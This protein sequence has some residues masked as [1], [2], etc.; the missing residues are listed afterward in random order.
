MLVFPIALCILFVTDTPAMLVMLF[1]SY[2]LDTNYKR[3]TWYK[4][5]RIGFAGL[6]T[7]SVIF[8]V[9]SVLAITKVH[10]ISFVG[11]GEAVVSGIM[12]FVGFLLLFDLGR[13][14]K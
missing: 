5:G 3:F 4:S 8:L 11:S 7:A 14:K 10:M 9:R 1:L 6:F 13:L 2:Y 12:A